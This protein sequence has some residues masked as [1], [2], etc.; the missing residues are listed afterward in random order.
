M[1]GVWSL[2]AALSLLPIYPPPPCHHTLKNR[3]RR[4]IGRA[5]CRPSS[6]SS[7]EISKDKRAK[8]VCGYCQSKRRKRPFNSVFFSSSFLRLLSLLV[9]ASYDIKFLLCPLLYPLFPPPARSIQ[10]LAFEGLRLP[11]SPIHM[12]SV[13][14]LGP[15]SPKQRQ[16]S[17]QPHP[18]PFAFYPSFYMIHAAA[19]VAAVTSSP[20]PSSR[21]HKFRVPITP[22]N[23]RS[24][25]SPRAAAV[26]ALHHGLRPQQEGVLPLPLERQA[27]PLQQPLQLV[28]LLHLLWLSSSVYFMFGFLGGC[29]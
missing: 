1:F 7:R 13:F 27:L 23:P 26:V 18:F 11:L 9:V 4:S 14:P 24:H 3:S 20:T 28:Q 25:P 19:A 22:I 16:A 12:K 6:S 17:L 5:P 15:P 10:K 29:D 8:R 2:A 21:I